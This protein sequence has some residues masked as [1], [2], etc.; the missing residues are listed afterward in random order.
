MDA[1]PHERTSRLACGAL[2]ALLGICTGCLSAQARQQIGEQVFSQVLAA[3][4]E[5]MASSYRLS[6]DREAMAEGP[7]GALRLYGTL[8]R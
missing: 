5:L 2:V 8:E 6:P 1:S 4:T 3:L 7:L